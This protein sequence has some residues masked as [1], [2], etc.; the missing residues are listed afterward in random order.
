MKS[1]PSERLP[2]AGT[3]VLEVSIKERFGVSDEQRNTQHSI[4]VRDLVMPS[5]VV[6]RRKGS[7]EAGG[8]PS[9]KW[10]GKEG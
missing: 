5:A 4:F 7:T 2:S 9:G 6:A 3:C 1:S 8:W 10:S